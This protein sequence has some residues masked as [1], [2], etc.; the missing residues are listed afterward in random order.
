MSLSPDDDR[1]LLTKPRSSNNENELEAAIKDSTS[2]LPLGKSLYLLVH[3][4]GHVFDKAMT[5]IR[6]A[7]PAELTVHSI[8]SPTVR[9]ILSIENY[10]TS[11]K[12][13]S[14]SF[15]HVYD[16]LKEKFIKRSKNNAANEQA[17]RIIGYLVLYSKHQEAGQQYICNELSSSDKR[18]QLAAVI[19]IQFLLSHYMSSE[20]SHNDLA[21]LFIPLLV[22]ISEKYGDTTTLLA[23]SSCDLALQLS[24]YVALHLNSVAEPTSKII[25]IQETSNDTISIHQIQK[26]WEHADTML[27]RLE[28]WIK[29]TGKLET[30]SFK[31]LHSFLRYANENIKHKDKQAEIITAWDLISTW[32]TPKM[33][34]SEKPLT[35]KKQKSVLSF[36]SAQT[37][38][39]LSSIKILILVILQRDRL[40]ELYGPDRSSIVFTTEEEETKYL[41][42]KEYK[43]MLQS[44]PLGNIGNHFIVQ[45]VT[46][47]PFLC[48]TDDIQSTDLIQQ[49]LNNVEYKK[50]TEAW[51]IPLLMKQPES[52]ICNLLWNILEQN[53]KSTSSFELLKSIISQGSPDI[54][55]LVENNLLSVIKNSDKACELL[56]QCMDYLHLPSLIQK[57]MPRIVTEDQREKMVYIALISK[58]LLH[59]SWNNNSILFHID[60]VR[61]FQLL[62]HFTK[63]NKPDFL[64]LTPHNITTRKHNLVESD[65]IYSDE[66]IKKMSTYL[67]APIQ[68]WSTKVDENLLKSALI[69]LVRKSYGLPGDHVCI[70]AWRNLSHAFSNNHDLIWGVMQECIAIMQSHT[71]SHTLADDIMKVTPML[72]LQTIPE[73]SFDM[74]SLPKSY[75]NLL[76]KKFEMLAIDLQTIKV[77]SNNSNTG[78]SIQ[79]MDELL[80]RCFHEDWKPLAQF[81]TTLI[82]K[83][84]CN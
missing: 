48:T 55:D 79:L 40:V 15:K 12:D 8:E 2:D 82:S 42:Q 59:P 81:A 31:E 27:Y 6:Q 65:I 63:P 57:L 75:V 64:D 45:L 74:V 21:S 47:L 26:A 73:Q 16:S 44:Y 29:S 28:K 22:D 4:H 67:I 18:C 77:S 80:I 23:C 61:E 24:R 20:N 38:P 34:V 46:Q 62:K 19:L 17:M 14:Q 25:E 37:M 71:I 13:T 84:F 56:I 11:G 54:I 68:L 1:L 5:T 66:E 41:I 78:I 72:I 10:L 33:I 30:A 76:S 69:Q 35:V 60:L 36:E 43:T 70:D 39:L 58:A 7:T 9:A 53:D 52:S 51:L 50:E 32:L 3:V 83:I 49:I